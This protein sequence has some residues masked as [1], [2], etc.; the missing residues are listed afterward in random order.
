MDKELVQ[1]DIERDDVHRLLAYMKTA[2]IA[3][4]D[5]QQWQASKH[6][7]RLHASLQKQIFYYEGSDPND[8]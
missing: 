8:D 1:I 6:A 2:E 4:G 3:Y 5:S 7:G